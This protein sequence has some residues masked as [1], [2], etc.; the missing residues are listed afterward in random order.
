M[1]KARIKRKKPKVNP[2]DARATKRFFVITGIVVL[3]LLVLLFT[4]YART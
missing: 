1:A 3:V 2:E 4:V